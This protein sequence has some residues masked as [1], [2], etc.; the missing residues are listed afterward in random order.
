MTG[1]GD[2]LRSIAGRDGV[3]AALL[4]S[5]DGL[6]IEHRARGP[7]DPETVA[8]LAATLAQYGNRFGLSVQRGDLRT[9]V[10]EFASGMVVLA[11]VGTGDW[12]AVL[13]V[14]DADIGPLLSDLR[15]HRPALATL[16]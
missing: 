13:A 8:A 10:F 6:P 15:H 11:Q 2:V 14:P 7:F 1:L 12:L 16:L 5:A 4:L 9:A 3:T